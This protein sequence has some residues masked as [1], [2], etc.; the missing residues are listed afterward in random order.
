MDMRCRNYPHPV[1]DY[2]SDNFINCSFQVSISSSVTKTAYLLNVTAKTSCKDIVKLV[3][4]KKACYAVHVECSPTMYRTIFKSF[5][6]N[7]TIEIPSNE[8]DGKVQ[9]CPFILAAEDIN[10]YRNANFH[11]DYNNTSFKV[12]KGDVLAIDRDRDFDAMKETDVLKNISSIFRVRKSEEENAPAHTLDIEGNIIYIYLSPDNHM[13]YNYLQKDINLQP[14]LST[15]VIIP[16]IV[17]I[18]DII[19]S[20]DFNIEE[21][22]DKRWF[23]S[24]RRRLKELGMEVDNPDTLDESLVVAQKIIGDPISTALKSISE[25]ITDSD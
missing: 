18:I 19:K 14:V 17:N 22:E 21:F 25:F 3:E 10:G 7:F 23:R 4:D 5:D 20:S 6:E 9:L 15:M 8:V 16:A 11:P 1:L 24:L 13:L 12:R 2:Y